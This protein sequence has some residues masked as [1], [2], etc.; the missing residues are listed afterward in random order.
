MTLGDRDHILEKIQAY[1][2]EL[3]AKMEDDANMGE[4]G[5]DIIS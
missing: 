2:Q 3:F 5:Q 1:C 4:G